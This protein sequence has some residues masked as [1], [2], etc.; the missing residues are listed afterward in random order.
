[1]NAI[2]KFQSG[3]ITGGAISLGGELPV[4]GIAFDVGEVLSD[5]VQSDAVIGFIADN[6]N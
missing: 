4:V 6:L 5:I 3:D 2:G 1:M